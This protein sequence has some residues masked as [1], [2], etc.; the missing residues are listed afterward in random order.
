MPLVQQCVSGVSRWSSEQI[1]C[2]R[3]TVRRNKDSLRECPVYPAFLFLVLFVDL[4]TLRQGLDVG[5]D[6]FVGGGLL[7]TASQVNDG[8]MHQWL[9]HGRPYR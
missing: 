3:H 2:R 1:P 6:L 9:G 8:D 4:T 7:E 5:A